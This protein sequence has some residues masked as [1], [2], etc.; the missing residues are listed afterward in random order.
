MYFRTKFIKST[1]LVQLV[2]SY[3]N[4]E[5]LPRQRIVVSLGDAAIPD[6]DKTR[7]ARAVEAHMAGSVGLFAEDLSQEA[8]SW[9]TRIISLLGRSKSAK[10]VARIFHTR[11]DKGRES[12]YDIALKLAINLLARHGDF[13]AFKSAGAWHFPDFSG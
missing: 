2:E 13:I 5:G 12:P 11:L 3:R 1:A 6:V 4:T 8:A 7:I 10:P 9:V